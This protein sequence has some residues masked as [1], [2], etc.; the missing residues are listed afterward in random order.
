MRPINFDEIK[1]LQRM[2][3]YFQDCYLVTSINALS[4]SQNGCKILQNNILRE[5]NSFNIKFKN[6]NGKSEDF[7]ITE[8]EINDLTLCDEFLNPI[9][10]K[11]PE[12]PIL[13]AVEV[14]MNKLLNKYPDKKSFANR[15]C[16]TN[17]KFEYNNPS[18]FMEM[19]TGIKPLNINENSFKMTLKSKSEETKELL[20]KIGENQSHSFVVGTGYKLFK[21]LTNWHCYALEKVNN[22]DKSVQISDLRHREKIVLP[23]EDFIKKIK[24]ITGYFNE[25]LK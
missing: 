4:N 8:K 5:G 16:K 10:I 18:R 3:Q 6:I 1:T 20:K 7:F 14:A 12:N 2:K 19:F 15:L 17:E 22:T 13:K 11:E 24:F 23:F 9:V 25:D 21:G